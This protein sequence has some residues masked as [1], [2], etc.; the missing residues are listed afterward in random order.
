MTS[1]EDFRFQQRVVPKKAR[2]V[3]QCMQQG[4]QYR[5]TTTK[6]KKYGDDRIYR[7]RPR[8]NAQVNG[9][10]S[11]PGR[12][13][14][15]W[16]MT[17]GSRRARIGGKPVALADAF[18]RLSRR[19]AVRAKIVFLLPSCSLEQMLA[20]KRVAQNSAQASSVASATATKP[21]MATAT[22]PDDMATNRAG[23]IPSSVSTAT[24][25]VRE[26]PA[27]AAAPRQSPDELERS[28]PHE[29]LTVS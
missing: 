25:K 1:A 16:K 20:I 9:T 13:S 19:A 7:F 17:A 11:A 6:G 27:E 26:G 2:S 24:A 10:S 15:H 28:Y 8:H 3:R 12:L 4:L 18:G 21:R 23:L 14:Y 29:Q 22:Y 5:Q